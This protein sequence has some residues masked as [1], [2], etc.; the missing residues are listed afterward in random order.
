MS[1]LPHP[2]SSVGSIGGR[3]SVGSIG[4]RASVS[5]IAAPDHN[6]SNY[7]NSV[8]DEGGEYQ[9][10]GEYQN[11]PG[12]YQNHIGEYQNHVG[13]YQNNIG[14]YND[15]NALYSTRESVYAEYPGGV[16]P[17]SRP[18]PRAVFDEDEQEPRPLGP[19]HRPGSRAQ[20][21]SQH[22]SPQHG[23]FIFLYFPAFL[24]VFAFLL[25]S[26]FYFISLYIFKYAFLPRLLLIMYS[27]TK[28]SLTLYR[29]IS[30][31]DILHLQVVVLC[32]IS[33]KTGGGYFM[34]ILPFL[35]YISVLCNYD[36]FFY[37]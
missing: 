14:E 16:T 15:R 32:L 20:R 10:G 19:D 9:D 25:F 33:V 12:E 21:T 18:A 34:Y 27:R 3:A 29:F 6:Y 24:L 7:N 35:F 23:L 8:F 1:G 11:Q 28:Y 30:L 26:I 17:L 2:R 4:G 22:A 5:D 31:H 13:D 37:G 36:K